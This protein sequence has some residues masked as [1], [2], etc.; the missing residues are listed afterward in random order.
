MVCDRGEFA[1]AGFFNIYIDGI[2]RDL[3]E[4]GLGCYFKGVF[5][6]CLYYADDVIL[7]S[8]SVV[9]L[10]LMFNICYSYAVE[11]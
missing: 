7:L 1:L 2:I 4:S 11:W 8:G 6:G 3:E 9:K 5:A 10:Q